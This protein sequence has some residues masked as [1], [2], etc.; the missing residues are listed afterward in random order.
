MKPIGYF[1]F[2]DIMVDFYRSHTTH[3]GKVYMINIHDLD[4]LKQISDRIGDLYV[5]EYRSDLS[6]TYRNC[7]LEFLIQNFPQGI[8]NGCNPSIKE[9]SLEYYEIGF[10]VNVPVYIAREMRL[11]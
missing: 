9:F 10:Y 8:P 5:D 2:L 4:A 6:T 3:H 11:N 7:C 1:T